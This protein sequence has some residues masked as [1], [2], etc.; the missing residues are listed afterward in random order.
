MVFSNQPFHIHGAP[1]H[2]LPVYVAD[3]RLVARVFLAHA[4]SLRH[5]IFFARMKFRGFLHSFNPKGA[6]PS[7]LFWFLIC[8]ELAFATI[9]KTTPYEITGFS[10]SGSMPR[11]LMA[12]SISLRSIFPSTKSSCRVA[13]VMKRASTSKNS[14]SE[15]RPSLRP[16]PSVPK[17]ARRRGSHLLIMLGSVFR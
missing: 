2:L 7:A 9:V 11:S 10:F 3:Q 14:R 1:T 17:E 8:R 15:A 13:R 12:W 16:K 5:V 4:A 6:A